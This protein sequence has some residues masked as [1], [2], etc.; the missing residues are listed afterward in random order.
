MEE[1]AYTVCCWR[2]PNYWSAREVYGIQ[3]NFTSKPKIYYHNDEYF[4][5]K[6]TYMEDKDGVLF[7]GPYALQNK[8]IT[9]KVRSPEFDFGT[10]IL[11]TIPL[12]V[13]FPNFPF[14]CWGMDSLSRIGSA[15]GIPLYAEECKTKIERISYYRVH[16]EMDVTRELPRKI[17]LLDPNRKLFE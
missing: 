15:L 14:N 12:W 9:L 5:V 3:W 17:K 1:C 16:I 8:P 4:V 2:L 11:Q 10:E 7:S 6:F 13:R